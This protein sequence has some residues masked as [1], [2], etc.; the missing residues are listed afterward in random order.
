VYLSWF[1]QAGLF[2]AL[3]MFACIGLLIFTAT[4]MAGRRTRSTDILFSLIAAN[5]VFLAHGFTDF[6]LEMFAVA[7]FWSYLL[8][9]QFGLAQGTS[10]R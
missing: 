4:R 5:V 1:E 8:G 6:A 2:G 7:A 9:L 10:R 3:L